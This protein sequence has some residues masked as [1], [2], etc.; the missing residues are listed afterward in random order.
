VNKECTSFLI[1]EHRTAPAH[2]GNRSTRHFSHESPRHLGAA[3]THENKQIIFCQ[4]R[5]KIFITAWLLATTQLH[6]KHSGLETRKTAIVTMTSMTLMWPAHEEESA[7]VAGSQGR[8]Q[9]LNDRKRHRSGRSIRQNSK[10]T[11]ESRGEC[12][13]GQ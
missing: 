3:K 10:V 9:L 4:V 8:Q 1:Y 5:V 11:A 2:L 6:E 12:P 7:I 13:L